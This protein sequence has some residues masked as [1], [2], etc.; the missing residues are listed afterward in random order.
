MTEKC[1][2]CNSFLEINKPIAIN[3]STTC[4]KCGLEQVVIWLYPLELAK[5]LSTKADSSPGSMPKDTDH[6]TS[7]G[8]TMNA[9]QPSKNIGQF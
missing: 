7:S 1:P 3:Q 4:P 5:A 2:I 9:D 8:R 6:I